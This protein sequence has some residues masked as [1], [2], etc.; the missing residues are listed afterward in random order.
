[1]STDLA[2]ITWVAVD[3]GT[4]HLRIWLMD[5]NDRVVEAR[6]SDRGMGGLRPDEFAGALGALLHDLPKRDRALPVIC[7]GMVGSRQG[8]AE[9]PYA[10]V[11]CP[12]PGLDQAT[13]LQVQGWDVRILPGLKQMSP[14]DVMRGE[15]TQIA[16]FL[17]GAGDFDGVVCLPGTHCKWAHISAGEVVSFR[18]YMTG[19][20]F[21]L[22]SRQ[23]VLRHSIAAEG[24]DDA[25]FD[26][27]L[28]D[29]LSRP[30]EMG[31]RLFSLRA[32]QLLTGQ[33]PEVARAR[34]SGLL[35]GIELAA[36]KPYWL[37]QQ[38]AIVGADGLSA[39][40]RRALETQGVQVTCVSS[41]SITLQ[42]LTAA[43]ARLTDE[44]TP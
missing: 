31:A 4:S 43:H 39:A 3:W 44:V 34:L 30:S 6:R 25:A 9:A 15:E 36:A 37:G 32:E 33:S 5:A 16:G 7:C 2:R 17:A 22:L 28:T 19:E 35:I 11:P 24:W 1:M 40:Y 14:A 27:A 23:S 18:T 21:A 26:A 41:D 12:P 42:G 13:R 10:Q 8:W 29:A 20:L 38:V